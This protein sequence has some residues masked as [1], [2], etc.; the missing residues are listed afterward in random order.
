[1]NYVVIVFLITNLWIFIYRFL[2]NWFNQKFPAQPSPSFLIPGV[3]PEPF[4]IPLYLALVV[5]FSL[6]I[7]LAHQKQWLKVKKL[8]SFKNQSGAKWLILTLLFFIFWQQLGSFPL[9]QEMA[10]YSFITPFIQHASLLVAAAYLGLI[11]LLIFGLVKLYQFAKQKKKVFL[12]WLGL[13]LTVA[14]LTFEPGFPIFYIDY[15]PFFGPIQEI[16]NGSTIYTDVPSHY[17]FLAILIPAF[18]VKIGV[19]KL[20]SLPFLIWGLYIAQYCLCFY[21]IYKVSRSMIFSLL[22]LFSIITINYFSLMHLPISV[23]QSGAARWFQLVLAAFFFYKIKNIHSKKL[24][25]LLAF[26]SM[27]FI[28]TGLAITAAYL[29]TLF[30][31]WLK[32][33]TDWKKVMTSGFYYFA[34][35]ILLFAL[36]NLIFLITGYKLIDGRLLFTKTFQYARFGVNMLPVPALTY[37]WWVILFYFASIVVF[38]KSK[39]TDWLSQLVVL[40]ANLSLFGSI[41]YLGRSHPN[42]L[43]MV[44]ILPLLNLFLLMA[45]FIKKVTSK[46]VKLGIYLGIVIL[47]I[48]V[49]VFN[50][51]VSLAYIIYQKISRL[52][53][54][55]YEE[56]LPPHLVYQFC[57]PKEIHLFDTEIRECVLAKYKKEKE[58]INQNMT[59]EEIVII[60]PDDTYLFYLTGKKN[61]LQA[62]PQAS[63]F[64]ESDLDFAVKRV[65]DKC[66]QKLV[67]DSRVFGVDPGIVATLNFYYTIQPNLLKKIEQQCKVRFVRTKCTQQLCIAESVNR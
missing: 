65:A 12:F 25:F 1:M 51:R 58:L 16:I 45:V 46:Q 50:R 56:K 53:V 24:V 8:S 43:L 59:D 57:Q 15:A 11:F 29:L 36:I 47:L 64:S 7:W 3:K 19:L 38:F 33:Q 42:V 52:G 32:R 20:F 37:F 13:I 21:L 44:S 27:L 31:F 41:Y 61:M 14:F 67:V 2:L 28:D 26:L 63:I 62:N 9:N 35:L 4:E 10:Q 30:F 22:G 48:F 66:P 5:I 54:R 17:G 55:P 23:P 34:F 6:L 40:V 39:K 18:L 49:P 60:S